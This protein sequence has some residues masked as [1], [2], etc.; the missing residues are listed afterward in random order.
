M[1]PYA[2]NR[3]SQSGF[4]LIEVLIVIAIVGILLAFAV[5]SYQAFMTDARRSDAL[6]VLQEV[7]GEQQK[8]FTENNRFANDL[9]ELGYDAAQASPE[10]HYTVT[11]TTPVAT[12]FVLTAAPVAGGPQAGDTECGSFTLDSAGVKG[13]TGSS[14]VAHCW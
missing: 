12:S 6:V 2:L 14:S 3:V 9:T 10:G 1:K 4:T 13:I 5:P 8:F 7:A 11:A